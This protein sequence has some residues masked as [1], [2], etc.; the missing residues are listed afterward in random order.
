MCM[1]SI[2]IGIVGL[3]SLL[4]LFNPGAG[5]FE[6]LP[7]NIPLVGNVDEMTATMLL[8]SAL[9]YFGIDLSHLFKREKK[10]DTSDKGIE[11]AESK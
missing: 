3:L 11:E 7:D 4:Y 5:V 8:L 9:G 6:F 1:K 10:V 2:F